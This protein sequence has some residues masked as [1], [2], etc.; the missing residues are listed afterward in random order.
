MYLWTEKE[1]A[2]KVGFRN[3]G[4]EEMAAKDEVS[5]EK[6]SKAGRQV[7]EKVILGVGMRDVRCGKL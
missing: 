5:S 4:F 6:R 7:K 3:G 1:F 2:W